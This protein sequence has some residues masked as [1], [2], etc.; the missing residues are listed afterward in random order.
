MIDIVFSHSYYYKFDAKQWKNQ[1]PYPPLGTMYAASFLRENG[2]SV[3]IFDT[4]LLDNPKTIKPY[5]K[6]Q[7]PKTNKTKKNEK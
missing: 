1:T 4:N 3:S 6:T 2:Y 5:L 7:Q